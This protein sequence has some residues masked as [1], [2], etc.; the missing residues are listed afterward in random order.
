MD[1][2]ELDDRF[3]RHLDYSA[4]LQRIIEDLCR[5]GPI[6]EPKTSAR[7]HY[8]M[9]VAY[10]AATTSEPDN[11]ALQIDLAIRNAGLM[12]DPV[13]DG[14]GKWHYKL[15]PLAATSE[16]VAA[17]HCVTEGCE[18][19]ATVHFERGGVGSWFCQPCY[20]KVQA[21]RTTPPAAPAA[22]D[23]EIEALTTTMQLAEASEAC[24]RQWNQVGGPMNYD[25][26]MERAEAALATLKATR[27]TV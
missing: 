9:A 8:D 18:H 13:P 5:G 7:F 19:M 1:K 25:G 14:G 2:I 22:L 15:V 12:L 10:L 20:L 21:L 4:D 26:I 16:P 17:T 6:R 23:V 24:L 27:E 3:A 11:E